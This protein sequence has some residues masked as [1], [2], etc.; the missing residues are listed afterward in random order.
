MENESL[1]TF[2][3]RLRRLCEKQRVRGGIA[4]MVC[5]HGHGDG[6]WRWRRRTGRVLVGLCRGFALAWRQLLVTAESASPPSFRGDNAGIVV[7]VLDFLL[8]DL[9]TK[10]S[11]KGIK[12]LP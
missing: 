8:L 2:S 6:K 4:E 5:M 9:D 1:L 3:W 11:F 7:E 10:F 12:L